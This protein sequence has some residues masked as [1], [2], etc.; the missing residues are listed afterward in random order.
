MQLHAQSLWIQLNSRAKLNILNHNDAQKLK[1][2]RSFNLKT[3]CWGQKQHFSKL[4]KI[5]NWKCNKITEFLVTFVDHLMSLIW[6]YHW[7]NTQNE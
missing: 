4:V 5:E 6:F 2:V 1:P 7:T 3:K